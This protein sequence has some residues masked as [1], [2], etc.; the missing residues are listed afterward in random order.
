MWE[1]LPWKLKLR[2]GK[3]IHNQDM[4]EKFLQKSGK[5]KK[6][7]SSKKGFTL[8]EL[9]ISMVIFVIF[10]GVVTNSYVS[11]VRNQ[12]QA[13]EVRK[14]Y[15][16]VRRFMDMFAQ[17]VRL[18]SIDYACYNNTNILDPNA[19]TETG[20]SITNGA[21]NMLLLVNKDGLERS[22]FSYVDD[23]NNPGQIIIKYKKYVKD[24]TTASWK[25]ADGFDSAL[26]VMSDS[27]AVTHLAF[28][29]SPKDNPYSD[30]VDI[31]G[32][33]ATQFQ[34]KV[35]LLMSVKNSRS[36]LADFSMDYQTTIS[37]RVYSR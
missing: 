8:I 34:P 37:S 21:A 24:L 15:S 28:F 36:T 20:A 31:Y 5:T 29:I 13:N 26:P 3:K 23:D 35:T 33:A 6:I 30:L 32:N 16:D 7:T 2:T 11:I 19:C 1:M 14:M 17:E 12:R 22:T 9:L 27:V 10:L 4:L 25:A 18:S